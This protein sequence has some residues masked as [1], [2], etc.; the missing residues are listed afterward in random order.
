MYCY[1]E[2]ETKTW[3]STC[4]DFAQKN[5]FT[6]YASYNNTENKTLKA[7]ILVTVEHLRSKK[8]WPVLINWT[9]KQ[10][11][12]PN[13]LTASICRQ[14]H[15]LRWEHHRHRTRDWKGYLCVS[16]LLIY[17]LY[18]CANIGNFRITYQIVSYLIQFL[19][20]ILAIHKSKYFSNTY[21]IFKNATFVQINIILEQKYGQFSPLWALC[22]LKETTSLL[23]LQLILINNAS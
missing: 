9:M 10:Q 21:Q 20:G 17:L 4:N 3:G 1:S 23:L 2:W 16:S 6:A 7:C 12:Q 15:K 13:F 5:I 19:I 22:K 18:G 8:A 14:I 11:T